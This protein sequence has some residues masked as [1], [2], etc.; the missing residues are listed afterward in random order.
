MDYKESLAPVTK[1]HQRACRVMIENP[2]GGIPT[3]TFVE[4]EITTYSDGT[5]PTHRLVGSLSMTFDPNEMIPMIDP[6]TNLSTETLYP[7]SLAQWI[8]YSMYWLK[9]GERDNPPKIEAE[10]IAE[11]AGPTKRSITDG[12]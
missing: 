6:K 12:S 1:K 4:E 9:A 11:S 8:I 2:L 7:A 5:P 10:P 3:A